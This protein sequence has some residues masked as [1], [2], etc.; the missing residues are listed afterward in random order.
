MGGGGERNKA[1]N[2]RGCFTS[3]G[4]SGLVVSVYAFSSM[5]DIFGGSGP[6]LDRPPVLRFIHSFI[7]QIRTGFTLTCD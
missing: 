1:I 3:K 7:L 4:Q 6:K 2:K 5:L